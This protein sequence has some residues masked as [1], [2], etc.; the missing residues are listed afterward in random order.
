MFNNI[1]SYFSIQSQNRGLHPT[2]GLNE[3]DSGNTWLVGIFLFL[4][5]LLIAFAKRTNG[6]VLLTITRLFVSFSTTESLQK[7]DHKLDSFDA[8]GLLINF[9]I[10][11]FICILLFINTLTGSIEMEYMGV[12]ALITIAFIVYQYAGLLA[13]MW[14]TGEY[15]LVRNPLVQTTTGL[16][17]FGLLLFSLALIWFLN[18][19]YNNEL[20]Y[21]FLGL[22]AFV[23]VHRI[24]RG[25][26]ICLSA[27]AR[28]YYI[29]L[30]FC[31]LEILPLFVAYYYFDKNFVQ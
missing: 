9:I 27:G 2:I 16:E 14:L 1:Q 3:L 4:S 11:F 19:Q 10:S 15:K 30:Y 28:W 26:I 17:F 21:V 23:I 22:F 8:F 29:I 5:F 25:I 6:S 31:A 24:V 20:F 7:Y 12:S 13:T 18:P